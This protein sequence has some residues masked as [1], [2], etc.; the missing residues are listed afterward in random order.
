MSIITSIPYPNFI[1]GVTVASGGQVNANNAALIAQVN[2]NAAANG[3][4]ADITELTALTTPPLGKGSTVFFGGAAGGT[5]NAIVLAS[6]NPGGFTAATGNR[7]TFVASAPPTGATTI[8]PN[9]T[10]AVAIM[11]WGV[12]GFTALSGNEWAANQLVEVQ[13]DGTQYQLISPYQLVVTPFYVGEIRT[14]A[15][16]AAPSLWYAC[17][18]QAVSRTTYATLFAKIGTT[19]GVGDGSTTFNLPNT[20]GEFLRGFDA[21]GAIDPGRVFGSTQADAVQDHKHEYGI[22]SVNVSGGPSPISTPAGTL[23]NT[24]TSGMSTGTVGT[25]TRPKNVAMLF[26]IYAG[27]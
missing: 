24:L 22:G 23:F 25:E 11:K 15:M 6:L 19:Y 20:Q 9:R 2:A 10:G 26:A 13:Y 5:A 3:I 21:S 14:F 17:L 4:N 1:D 12:S 8:N 16:N 18:G 27:V 7:I